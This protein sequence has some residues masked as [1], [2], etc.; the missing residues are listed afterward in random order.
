MEHSHPLPALDAVRPWRTATMVASAIAA[1]ELLLLVLVGIALI[2]KPLSRKAEAAAAA[3]L[4]V[5]LPKKTTQES[6]VRFAVTK[7]PALARTATRVTVLNGNGEQ[8]AAAAQAAR[9]RQHGY[10]I[11][12]VG[13]A[14]KTGYT[15]SMVM[16]R[17]RFRPEAA[18]L[19]KD[20]GIKI[21]TPLDGLSAGALEGAQVAVIVG[22]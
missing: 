22:A 7:K 1:A 19:A 18:R 9:V 17:G 8:G 20:L 21:V 16:Y 6:P 2:G 11:A 12:V 10:P 14:P 15:R 13:N 3:K 5:P 4:A